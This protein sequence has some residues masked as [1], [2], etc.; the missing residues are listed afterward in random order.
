[1]YNPYQFAVNR[2]QSGQ[3]LIS[4]GPILRLNDGGMDWQ[5]LTIVPL[6]YHDSGDTSNMWPNGTALY[7]T[8]LWAKKNGVAFP[9]IPSPSYMMAQGLNAKPAFYGCN[10]TSGPL[11]ICYQWSQWR[12]EYI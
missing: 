12:C 4:D 7:Y 2:K 11:V 6:L 8:M 5:N 10:S 9:N 1:M 3:K